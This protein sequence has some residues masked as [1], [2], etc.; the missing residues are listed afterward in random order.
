MNSAKNFSI[1]TCLLLFFLL[2]CNGLIAQEFLKDS[3][4]LVTLD[5]IIIS[6]NK[7]NDSKKNIAQQ[8]QVLNTDFIRSQQSQTTADLLN[9]SGNVF[10]QK[11]QMGGGSIVIRG[12]EANRISLVIDGVKMNNIIYRSGHLQNILSMDNNYL[13][14]VE[15]LYGPSSTIYGSDALGGAIYLSTKKLNFATDDN[16]R[17]LKLNA[18]SRFSSAN[19]ETTNHIDFNIANKRISSLTSFTYSRFGDLKSGKNQNPFYDKFYGERN[20]YADRID[21]NDVLIKNKNRF[22][23]IGSGYSQ[24]DLLQ[25][26]LFQQTYHSSHGLNIQYSNSS[27]VPRYDRLTDTTASGLK[28]A[29]WYYGP[30]SRILTAYDFNFENKSALFNNVHLGLNYQ[31]VK[32]SRHTR[33]FG[34]NSL[35]NRMEDVSI[36]G[37][38]IDLIQSIKNHKIRWGIDA[39][40]NKLKSTANEENIVTGAL[41]PLDTRYPDGDNAMF[42]AALYFSHTWKLSNDLALTDGLRLGFTSLHSTFVDTSFFHFPFDKIDQKHIVYSGNIGLIHTP[43][44]D[45]KLSLLLSSGFR[46]PNVDDLSKVFESAAGQIIVPNKDLKPEKTIN[47]E[48]G[49]EKIF[50]KKSVWENSIYYTNFIDGIVTSPY[51]FNGKDSILYQDTYSQV[52]SNQNQR[53]AYLF[54]FSS[55]IKSYLSACFSLQFKLNY[56]YGRIKTVSGDVPLDHIPPLTLN[57]KV[58][59]VCKRFNADFF[60]NYNSRKKITDYYLNGEDNEQYATPEG[61]PAWLTA[62]LHLLYKYNKYFTVKTGIENI[63]DTQYRT[64]ASGINAPGRNVFVSLLFNK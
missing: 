35:L 21:G 15:I 2:R 1:K 23:Q 42:N 19:N 41:K 26:I 16:K 53:K 50:N 48:L 11:S 12:F 7:S 10:V 4:G 9:S 6:A 45:L 60:I 30:Q 59:Y 28:F 3:I 52:L 39:Q 18:C 51:L 22:L 38:N 36:L 44:D 47:Y 13:D 29:Q 56:T 24:Y 27:D 62:N 58:G 14:R 5:E 8:I 31:S 63:F 55:N 34:S 64:F 46:V 37:L 20:Y 25:K 32:E 17:L 33:K 54:G 49:I 57:F 61:M 43:T 40:Y